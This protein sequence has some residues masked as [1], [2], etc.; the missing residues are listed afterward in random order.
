MDDKKVKVLLL[1]KSQMIFRTSNLSPGIGTV[2]F[3]HRGKFSIF[4]LS[5]DLFLWEFD[6]YAGNT[7]LVQ[8]L[9]PRCIITGI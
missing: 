1:L 6:D 2:S 7:W 8:M 3:R 5:K 9:I 4:G